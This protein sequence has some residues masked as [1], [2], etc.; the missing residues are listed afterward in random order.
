M[1]KPTVAQPADSTFTIKKN[2]VEMKCT[3]KWKTSFGRERT[4]QFQRAQMMLDA[5]VMRVMEPYMPLDTGQLIKSMINGTRAGS[6][7][8]NVNTPYA[9]KVNY[10]TG[11]MGR[12][13]ALRGRRFFDRMKADKLDYLKNFVGKLLGAKVR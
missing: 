9:A 13:G 2:G 6:G 7:Q 8:V 4:E 12:N 1:A 11:I 5:E 10:V 3:L